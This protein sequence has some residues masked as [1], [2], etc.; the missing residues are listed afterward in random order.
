MAEAASLLKSRSKTP[1]ASAWMSPSRPARCFPS[2]PGRT[3]TRRFGP[4]LRDSTTS[5]PGH[6]HLGH[7][8]PAHAGQWRRS[9]RGQLDLV[10]SEG[11]LLGI[12]LL[13]LVIMAR[14]IVLTLDGVRRAVSRPMK[15]TARPSRLAVLAPR[16]RRDARAAGLSPAPHAARSSLLAASYPLAMTLF[17]DSVPRGYPVASVGRQVLSRARGSVIS[18]R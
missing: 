8:V 7:P 1:A 3:G 5:Y 2:R 13:A 9:A 15:P 16:A 10:Q 6:F 18:R 14:D 11:E 17:R 4:R 12:D